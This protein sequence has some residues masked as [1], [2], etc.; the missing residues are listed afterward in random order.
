MMLRVLPDRDP[1]YCAHPSY[2][3]DAQYSSPINYPKK[4]EIRHVSNE[5]EWGYG[6]LALRG[7]KDKVKTKVIAYN[8]LIYHSYCI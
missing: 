5:M 8:A 6:L 2:V 1:I 3:L 4:R 7:T